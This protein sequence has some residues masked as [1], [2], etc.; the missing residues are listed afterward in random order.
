MLPET[1]L[2]DS[3]PRLLGNQIS[4][5]ADFK[6]TPQTLLFISAFRPS[7]PSSVFNKAG[8]QLFLQTFLFLSFRWQGKHLIYF[9]FFNFTFLKRKLKKN[10]PP[11]YFQAF[12]IATP[13][14]EDG[15]R[16]NTRQT[17]VMRNNSNKRIKSVSNL[18]LCKGAC[19]A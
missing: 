7:P 19:N 9:Y 2:R 3:W 17:V 12:K 8:R 16:E 15:L 10:K 13:L 11:Q 1:I 6:S 18:L 14:A 4:S 5:K